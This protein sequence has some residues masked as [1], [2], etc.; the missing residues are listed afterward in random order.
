MVHTV[1]MNLS[2][3]SWGNEYIYNKIGQVMC[4][5]KF[6]ERLSKGEKREYTEIWKKLSTRG[7]T[8][9]FQPSGYK[10]VYYLKVKLNIEKLN[11]YTWKRKEKT[12]NRTKVQDYLLCSYKGIKNAFEEDVKKYLSGVF[13]DDMSLLEHIANL[14]NWNVRRIDYAVQFYFDDKEEKSMYMKLFRLGNTPARGKYEVKDYETESV[15]YKGKSYV[16]NTYDKYEEIKAHGGSEKERSDAEKIIRYEVQCKSGA[17]DY[18]V[19]KFK[20]KD[21]RLKWFLNKELAY[22]V[23]APLY[24]YVY[25]EGDYYRKEEAVK[26]INNSVSQTV[27][28]RLITVY[29][30]FNPCGGKRLSVWERLD[31]TADK[32]EKEKYK[33]AINELNELGINPVSL[34]SGTGSAI[35]KLASKYYDVCAKLGKYDE[36]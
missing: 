4:G 27:A 28:K 35:K 14:D 11:F 18:Y 29:E 5:E 7:I 20:L 23:L 26:I 10:Y 24:S 6:A 31:K 12:Y 22:N 2:L 1:E 21:K 36:F 17:V 30:K 16:V 3:R 33:I 32:K 15:Y 13:N 34:P 9:V 25:G 19:K 8:F